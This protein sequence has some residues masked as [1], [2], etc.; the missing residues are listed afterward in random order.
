MHADACLDSADAFGSFSAVHCRFRRLRWFLLLGALILYA[1]LLI[2][3]Q[4]ILVRFIVGL[5]DRFVDWS[6]AALI[7]VGFTFWISRW[8]DRWT[9]H[10][11]ALEAQRLAAAQAFAQLEAAQAT[12]RTVAHTINQPLAVIRG[13]TELYRDTPP[14]ER[15]DAD[16]VTILAHVD[17]AADLVRQFQEISRYHTIPYANGAP[18]LDL[19][20]PP[21]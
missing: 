6:V 3:S 17:R 9:T 19:S 16:L 2:A 21:A 1:I 5:D 13:V 12:A 15:D 18:M 14:A 10:L 20:P 7:G 4:L 8:E 11:S